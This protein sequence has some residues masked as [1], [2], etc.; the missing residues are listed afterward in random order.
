MIKNTTPAEVKDILRRGVTKLIKEDEIKETLKGIKPLRIKHGIDPSSNQIH[1]GYA[2][3]YRKLRQLQDLGHTVVFLVGDFTARFGDPTG[4]TQVRIMKDAKEVKNLANTY[5]EQISKILD[6]KRLEI[7]FNSEWYDKLKTEELF[8]V[9]A[10]FTTAQMLERDMFQERI[11]NKQEIFLHELLYPVLQG[12]DSVMLKSDLTV[13]GSDQIFNE[14]VGRDLQRSFNQKPQ[15]IIALE[16]LPG[17]DGTRKMSQSYGNT[18]GIDEPPDMQYGKIMSIPDNTISTYFELLTDL[19]EEE[20]KILKEAMANNKLNP[21]EAK[22]RLA[23]NIVSWLWGEKEAQAAQDEFKRVFVEKKLSTR[24]PE[25]FLPPGKPLDLPHYIVASGA[26]NSTTTAR[27]KISE[28]A[29]YIDGERA[30]YET[31]PQIDTTKE[32]IIKI[33]H[34]IIKTVPKKEDQE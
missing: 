29:V 32:H 15:G 11:T 12:Y 30:N 24:A 6:P 33:G 27:H 4:R 31:H 2:V 17:T 10:K 28:N 21:K 1:L 13:I 9:L 3:V 22:E 8:S 19:P 23:Y 34:T 26:A 18:I 7:R 16:V 14:I 20:I 25:H 5:V